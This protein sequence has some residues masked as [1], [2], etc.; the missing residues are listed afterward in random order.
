MG[1]FVNK[2][3][4]VWHGKSMRL[5]LVKGNIL[6]L[7]NTHAIV[8]FVYENDIYGRLGI[9]DQAGDAV[10]QEFETLLNHNEEHFAKFGTLMT[11]AGG[12]PYRYIIHIK[13]FSNSAKFK[14]AVI[15]AL[16]YA[17]KRD[18]R[19]IAFPALEDKSYINSYLEVFYDFEKMAH[20]RSLHMID[21]VT[22]DDSIYEYHGDEI[23]KRGEYLNG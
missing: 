14:N 2:K 22:N 9:M 23:G 11:R 10:K 16:R 13:V 15:L 5:E 20:P 12:L 3:V 6:S 19:S 4:C 7:E 1:L 21:I 8:N 18:C 17:E